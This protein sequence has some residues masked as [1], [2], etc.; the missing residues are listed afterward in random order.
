MRFLGDAHYLVAHVIGG[1]RFAISVLDGMRAADAI[2]KVMSSPQVGPDPLATWAATCSDQASAFR[3]PGALEGRIDHPLGDITGR[4][5]LEFRVFDIT[6]HAWDLARSI[7][8]DDQLPPALVDVVLRIVE[9]GPPG[10]GFGIVPLG[11]GLT[12]ASTQTR[13]LNLTGRQ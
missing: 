3:R 2:A 6:L 7:D 13:L 8:V 12:N 5:F 11:S 10:M 4:E 1:N 9:D